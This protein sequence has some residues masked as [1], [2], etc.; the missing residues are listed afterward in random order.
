MRWEADGRR[1]LFASDAASPFVRE[2]IGYSVDREGGT[3]HARWA[4]VTCA[5]LSA[6]ADG[7]LVIGRN[8]NDPAR[9]KRYRGG[10]AGDIWVDAT[11]GEHGYSPPDRA[12]GQPVWPMWL[13][14][15]VAFLSDHEGI[16]NIYSALPDGTDV[17][18]HT[19]EANTSP[20][21]RRPTASASS[22]PRGAQNRV[23]D[24]RRQPKS[25]SRSATRRRPRRKT[26]RRFVD[27]GEFL[28][29]SPPAPTAKRSALVSRGHRYTMPLWEE[30]AVQHGAGS[31]VR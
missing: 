1:I 26:A 14:E 17:R 5:T 22:T 29:T 16:G 18:R 25:P 6:N 12:A 7:R 2:T 19:D 28:E 15:R 20:A 10:T 23:V 21:F 9:W 3:P 31:G 30:A 8:N 13:G 24:P 27:V 4:S 11:G